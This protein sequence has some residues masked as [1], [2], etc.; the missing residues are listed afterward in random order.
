MNQLINPF[1]IMCD[2]E[3]ADG[4]SKT[5][6]G[7]LTSSSCDLLAALMRVWE[8]NPELRFGQ[9]IHNII[10]DPKSLFHI[11]NESMIESIDEFDRFID[12]INKDFDKIEV[13]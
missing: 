10:H 9:F 7:S 8:K 2:H 13:K 11:S 3:V 12:S 6:S 1:D 4:I 5:F